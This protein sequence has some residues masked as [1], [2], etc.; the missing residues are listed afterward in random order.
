MRNTRRVSSFIGLL[1]SAFG[2]GL[3]SGS[4]AALP[5]WELTGTSNH[6]RVLG[7]MHF[8]RAEDY[9]L[10][11]AIT[12]AFNEADVVLMEIDMDDLDP[13]ESAR[14]IASL[15]QDARGRKLPEL[16]GPKAWRDA[17]AEARK[18]N[19]DLT[20]LTPFEPWYAAVVVTQLRL[21]QLGFDQSLGVD[22]RI[23]ADA[24]RAGKEIRGFETLAGQLGILDALSADAQR[25]FLQA[26]LEE[27]GE[28]AEVA[29]GM[30]DAWK[31]GD[32]SAMDEDM[33]G[34]VRD[35]PEVYRT[36]I[37]RRNENFARVIEKLV[38]DSRDYLIVV[39]ALHLV[40]PDSVLRMLARDG[41]RSRQI[42]GR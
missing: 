18:L 34:S 17:T 19:L 22:A 37:I 38:D 6:I 14:T 7:S 25:V 11:P 3:A 20:P 24:Q 21:I 28:I 32:V 13:V 26:T 41:I 39:G 12:A 8:L 15:A 30:I 9:P 4:A 23:T 40:G 5:L 35:Q 33:L 10:H 2:L 36:L 27:A 31:S 1:V 42:E 29:D 16:L